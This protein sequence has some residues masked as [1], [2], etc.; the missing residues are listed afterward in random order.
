MNVLWLAHA[1]PYPPKAGFLIRS[2]NLLRELARA[3]NVDLIAFVQEAWIKTL[4][5]SLEE[6]LEESRHALEDFCRS[7][8][9]LPIDQL[10]PRWGKQTTALRALLTGS[11]YTTSWLVSEPARSAIARELGANSYDLVHFD[12]I[13]LAP[14]RDVTGSV[15]AILTHHNIESHMM[16]RRADNTPNIIARTYF[17]REAQRLQAIESR[18]APQFAAHI[19]CSDLDRTRFSE[20]VPDANIVVIPNGVDCEFFSPTASSTRPNSV[21]FVGSMNWYP[22]VAAM[23]FFL[24]EIWP[25]LKSG[26]PGATMD[27]AG[28]SPPDSFLKLARS[29]PDVTVHGYLPDVRPLIDS[30]AVY[31]CPIRDGGGTKLKILD[32]FAMKKCVVA[33][34]IACEGINVTAGTDVILASTPE[35]FVTEISRLLADAGLRIAIG[36]AARQLAESQYS[37]RRIGEQFNSTV[38]ETVQRSVARARR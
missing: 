30:A 24:R 17:R 34:P 2:Y 29:L 15:P 14:Y 4:F 18:I 1:V 32:A 31:V 38:I 26:V 37:F 11:T 27:I 28:S 25:R 21:V 13:G 22:N 23:L 12:T 16:K 3:Q 33:H 10:R 9:F 20:I 36:A 6:G 19:T 35:E 5:P 8:T 7:V